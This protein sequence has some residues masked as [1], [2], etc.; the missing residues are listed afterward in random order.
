M[1]FDKLDARKQRLD[2]FMLLSPEAVRNLH[3][4]SSSGGRTTPTP[5][6]AAR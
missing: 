2:G 4:A 3:G 1:N 6:R 5:S